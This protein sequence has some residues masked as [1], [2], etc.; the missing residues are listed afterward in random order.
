MTIMKR[1]FSIC[2]LALAQLAISVFPLQAQTPAAA[3]SA[4]LTVQV[5]KPGIKVSPTL[6]GIFFE[7]INH[8][9]DGGLYAE[10]VQNR[11]FE[12]SDKPDC[13]TLVTDGSA[14]G[15]IAI[16][17]DN[18]MCENNPRSLRLKISSDG[19]GKVGVANDGYWG[20]AVETD[21]QYDL[22]VALRAGD[23][24]T[25]P[26]AAALVSADLK[27]V[28]ARAQIDHVD[29]Q[30]KTYKLT[31]TSNA[32]DPKARLVLGSWEPGTLWMDMVS[33]FPR[34]TFKDRPNGMR[35]DLATMLENLRPSFVRFPG[36]C[37]V[38]GERLDNAMRWKRTIGDVAQRRNQWNLWQYFSTNGLG[39]HEY[40]QLCEDL[41]AEPLFVINCGMS[42][43]E[44]REQPKSTEG[45]SVFVQD[46]LDAIEY[47][48]GP[49]DGKWGSLRAK[50]GHPAPFSL[51]YMEIGNE[52]GGP[53]YYERYAL[54]YDA[55][56]AKY[57]QMNLIADDWDGR[58]TN[59]PVEIID[60][61]Y[62]NSSEFFISNADKYDSYDRKGTKVYVGEYAV[63]Q[64]TGRGN[65]RGA[66]GEA[67][68]MTGMERNSDVVVLASY[69]PLFVN[70]NDRRWNPDMIQFDS[71]RVC[72]IPSYYVQQMFSQNRGHVILP[73]K[74]EFPAASAETKH[75][76]IGLGTWITQAE[77]KDIKVTK[78]DKTLFDDD[79]SN[80]SEGW[81]T[82]HGQWV[83]EDG[84][85]QQTSNDSDC[86]AT[87]GDPSWTDYTLS[88]KARKL[89]G[90]EGFLII[91][92][93]QPDN[94]LMW[95]NI[96]G[97]GNTK[98]AL[99]RRTGSGNVPFG[100]DVP[101]RVETDRWYDVRVEVGSQNVRCFLDDKL[102]HDVDYPSMQTLYSVAGLN[103][104]GDEVI[105]K[106][107]NASI[108]AQETD[109][110]LAGADIV[111]PSG[112]AIVLTSEKPT[113]ENT[114]DNPTK[115]IPV[116]HQIQDA[117]KDFK[118]TFPADSVTVLR[119]KIK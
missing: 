107:V 34:K 106:V 88:L 33:L 91:F 79:F 110:H 64:N 111:Q 83:V 6:Y 23:G 96:G 85:L 99:E 17:T 87:A 63:T 14:K 97:W 119:L 22:S 13:W 27:T 89:G 28:Y 74:L 77:Y 75:G 62:Y 12:N 2:A 102:I 109:I 60:E 49:A 10:L 84:A 24:F 67:A 117:A 32:T 115:V 58:P 80:G 38:E 47:A 20:I 116:T 36:G 82:V 81:K 37:W 108:T 59:R 70:V 30:W 50:A 61:H 11:S 15:E 26:V 114:L 78:G 95:W 21:A 113:D 54:F 4:S 101:G 7:E 71:S 51:K 18:P 100:K 53:A 76:A 56:K 16:D 57:P 9:G 103:K 92:N 112:T 31:L 41:G 98:H 118:Y 43:Q 66:V 29:S 42:H 1:C 86:V 44:Q 45:V 39:F 52:N 68:F 48:T 35:L 3:G 46:A 93:A 25:A 104:T 90:N 65:L 55:I 19:Q 94:Q 69:A 73:L 5:D 105:L 8:A 40:L 72:A